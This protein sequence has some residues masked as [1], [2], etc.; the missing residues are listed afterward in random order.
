VQWD[1]FVIDAGSWREQF[2]EFDYIGAPWLQF[3]DGYDVG[4]GGF[5]LR[6]RRL[7]EACAG[8]D[9]IPSHPE[10]VAICRTNR[11]MLEKMHGIRFADAQLA[12]TF[13]FERT[14]PRPSFGFHGAFNLAPTVGA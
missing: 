12:E 1:G 14:A 4:N 8:A 9:F 7:L 6:S 3:A 2:L 10:D 5:S 13:A 11:P